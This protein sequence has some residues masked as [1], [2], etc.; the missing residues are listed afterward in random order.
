MTD[1]RVYILMRSTGSGEMT[2]VLSVHADPQGAQAAAKRAQEGEL[3]TW[4]EGVDEDTGIRHWLAAG[5][6]SPGWH[7]EISERAVLG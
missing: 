5:M 3:T 2:A 6:T 7:Y 1:D 4:D